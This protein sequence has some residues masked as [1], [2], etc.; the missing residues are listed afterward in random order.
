ME[1]GSVRIADA[2]KRWGSCGKG[3]SL[4]F[5]WRLILA[6]LPVLDC[7]VIHELVHTIE[8]NHA[9]TFW[10]KLAMMCPTYRSSIEWLKKNEN[11]LHI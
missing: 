9:R 2:R 1:V 8:R 11:L 3:G 10:S 5:S 7:V 6:P 4:N